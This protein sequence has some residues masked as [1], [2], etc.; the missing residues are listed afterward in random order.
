MSKARPPCPGCPDERTQVFDVLGLDCAEEVALI[1]GHLRAL[2][3]ICSVAASAVSGRAT[4]VHT[5]PPGRVEHEIGSLGLRA[6]EARERPPHRRP[7]LTTAGAAVLTAAGYVSSLAGATQASALYAAAIVVGGLPLAR[8][9]VL[10]A[11]QGVLDMNILMTVAVLGA[12]A[13]GEWAE[14]ATTVVLFSLAQYLEA[15]S[16]ERARRAIGELIESSPDRALVRRDGAELRVASDRVLPGEIVLVAPGERFPLDGLV[17]AGLTEADQGEITG[18]SLPVAKGPGD[19]VFAGSVNGRGLVEV[20]VTRPAGETTR[21]RIIRRVEEA[22]RARSPSQ[23]F[24]DRFARVY[25]PAVVLFA[26][27]VALAPPALLGA[28]PQQWIYRAL[29]LLV[30]SCPCAL[31]ISTP[32]AVV[33]ALTAAS[34]RGILIKGGAPLEAVGRVRAVVFDKTGTLTRG[35]PEV[36]GVVPAPGSDAEAVIATAA[37]LA[38]RSGHPLARAL[39]ARAAGL[40]GP[41]AGACEAEALPGRGIRG[42]VG[43]RDVLMGSHRLFDERG[44]C[45][46]SLDGEIAR[47]E[48]QGSSTILVGASRDGSPLT[49]LGVV[50]ISSVPRPEAAEAMASLGRLGLPV[51]MLT[52]DNHRTAAAVA[53][54]LSIPDFLA[55]QLPEEKADRLQELE[56]SVGEIAMV[57]DGVNDAAA[58]AAASVG[59]AMGG[60]SSH[61]TLETA[62]IA[63][64]SDDLRRVPEAIRL[65]RATRRV[66][67]QNVCAALAVKGAVLCLALLGYGSLWAAVAADMGA[68]LLVIGNSLRLL[69]PA[70]RRNPRAAVL[71]ASTT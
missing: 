50:A 32:V 48:E 43:D 70:S 14:G 5:L 54:Q 55:E 69:S 28:P 3:G 47:L 38:T 64:V 19:E 68:S 57:G 45:D 41:G 9:G 20:E 23:T 40:C 21:A 25:T 60:A 66:I 24:V 15:R 39:E 62:D 31:V 22:Q 52:G 12:A 65:G 29:V 44:L 71:E 36:T 1:E 6:R 11:R 2:E 18:E 56:A 16:M 30:I 35:E 51:R 63:L 17:R 7:A 49:L 61:A 4:V 58:L 8:R 27:V 67:V 59:I 34:R 33:S 37:A 26:F 53:A 13:I 46:H 10:R 42:R